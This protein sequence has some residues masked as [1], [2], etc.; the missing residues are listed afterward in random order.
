MYTINLCSALS[1]P[2][3][4]FSTT[5]GEQRVS[6]MNMQNASTRFEVIEAFHRFFL[7]VD[8][9]D[10]SHLRDVLT[11]EVTA[12][13]T[14][15]WGGEVKPQTKDTLVESWRHTLSGFQATQHLLG[16]EIVSLDGETALLRAYFQAR[17][18]LP[19]ERGSHLWTVGGR[20]TARLVHRER[21]WLLN[22]LTLHFSWADGNLNLFELATQRTQTHISAS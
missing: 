7:D 12:D 17:H 3:V 8:T 1:T 19:N 22:E 16:N 18:A 6:D 5:I 9:R 11:D 10:W 14:E 20:Y 15:L 2:F 21:G 4:R 13:Y